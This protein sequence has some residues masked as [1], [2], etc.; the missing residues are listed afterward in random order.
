MISQ[1]KE[2]FRD[3]IGTIKE[4]GKRNVIF[5]KKPKGKFT[6]YRTYISWFLLL[7]LVIAPFISIINQIFSEIII[8]QLKQ[9]IQTNVLIVAY[10]TD[11]KMH[12]II[13]E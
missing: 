11:L 10:Q 7:Q 9:I 6:N 4:D 8:C 5:P 3:S 13:E 1:D 12:M 2:H